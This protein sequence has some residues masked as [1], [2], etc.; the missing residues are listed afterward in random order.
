MLETQEES[1]IFETEDEARQWLHGFFT[2]YNE[3]DW[4]T[5][6]G[7]YVHDDCVFINANGIHSGKEKMIEFWETH[8]FNTKEETLMDPFNIFI[9]GNEVAAELPLKMTFKKPEIYA[10]IQFNEGDEILLSCADFYKFKD[11]KICKFKVY[12]FSDW[13]IKNWENN[14]GEYEKMVNYGN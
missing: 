4:D 2:A 9:R 12:R 10:G 5:F 11:R 3:R 13:W 14:L 1:N 6:F 7:T 8:I